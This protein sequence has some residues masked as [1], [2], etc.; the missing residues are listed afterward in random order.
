MSGFADCVL[1]GN[2]VPDVEATKLVSSNLSHLLSKYPLDGHIGRACLAPI[3]YL[4]HSKRLSDSP[5]DGRHL[6]EVLDTLLGCSRSDDQLILPPESLDSKNHRLVF[7]YP[8]IGIQSPWSS[9]VMDILLASKV[10]GIIQIERLRCYLLALKGGGI[11]DFCDLF[12]PMTEVVAFEIPAIS[13]IFTAQLASPFQDFLSTTL[14]IHEIIEK[15]DRQLGLGLGDTEKSLLEGFYGAKRTPT[16]AELMMFAQVHSEHCRHKLFKAQWCFSKRLPIQPSMF[17]HIKATYAANPDGVVLAY[18][19]NAAIIDCPP[20]TFL[21]ACT[22]TQALRLVK[23]RRSYVIKAET[24]NHP[25]AIAPYQGAATGSGGEIR[26]EVAVGRGGETLMAFAAFCVSDLHIPQYLMA[27]EEQVC[28]DCP[29]I[30]SPLAIMLEAPV[31]CANYNNEFGRP[32]LCG[33]FRTLLCPQGKSRY[34]GYHK[35]IMLVGGVG[36]VHHACTQKQTLPAGALVVQ[37]GG[38]ALRIG[39]GGGTGSSS[40]TAETSQALDFASVQ[41]E[42]AQVQRRCQGVI[43]YCAALGLDNPILSI[44][45]VGAG[46]LSNAIPELLYPGGGF[47]DLESIPTMDLGMNAMEIWCNE[48]QERYVAAVKAADLTLLRKICARETCQ[49]AVLGTAQ[50]DQVLRVFDKRCGMDVVHLPMSLLFTQDAKDIRHIDSRAL[51]APPKLGEDFSPP[52]TCETIRTA[53]ERILSLPSV[54]SKSFLITIGDRTVGGL[55]ARDQM[56]GPWQ[57]PVADAAVCAS[58]FDEYRG[59]ACALGERVTIA[60]TDAVASVRLALTEAV[61][62]LLSA[63]VRSLKHIK[64]SA[65]WMAD[66]TR[67][68]QKIALYQAVCAFSKLCQELG[69]V[70]PV[71]KDSLSMSKTWRTENDKITVASPVSLIVSTFSEV[72][73]IRKSLTPVLQIPSAGQK[74]ASLF[75]IDLG[76]R[77]GSVRFGGSAFAQVYRHWDQRPPDFTKSARLLDWHRVLTVLRDEKKILAYHDCS[78][79]GLFTCLVEMAFA[80]RCGVDCRFDSMSEKRSIAQILFEESPAVVVQL[81]QEGWNILHREIQGVSLFDRVFA[82]GR[83]V[84]TLHMSLR[85][86]G[87]KTSWPT[88]YLKRLWSE[89]SFWLQKIRGDAVSAEEELAFGCDPEDPGL[90]IKV[91]EGTFPFQPKTPPAFPTVIRR[92]KPKIAVLREQGSNGHKEMAAAFLFAG[93]EVYDVHMNDL[94]MGRFNLGRMLGMAICGGFSYGDACGAGKGWAS[95]ILHNPSLKQSFREFF[96]RDN[97]F[98]LGVCNG[99]Q[100][101]SQIAKLIPGASDWPRLER[102]ASQQFEARLVMVKITKT[103]SVFLSSMQGWHLPVAVAHSEGR[104]RFSTEVRRDD[105]KICMQYVD[106]HGRPTQHYPQ[107]PNAS[108]QAV[109]GVCSQ[110]GRVTIMMPHPERLFRNCQFSY[111]PRGWRSEESP[112]SESF[113]SAYRFATS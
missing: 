69:I 91:P 35:P 68:S 54:A 43:E 5:K 19:D 112:W 96:E 36:W 31:G 51:P 110:G 61:L 76:D 45:D 14:P 52:D 100:M 40:G 108:D 8:R 83:V 81:T 37:L 56:V 47:I 92:G 89:N 27:W 101:L 107:N 42:N 2:F 21:H 23:D 55:S 48:S 87:W 34:W 64:V 97:T 1:Y 82:I 105:T 113:R 44:H 67:D 28:M 17:S 80:G 3:Y 77:D 25:T 9:K 32:V 111:L 39:L 38:G 72:G 70:A 90:Y 30:A 99:C 7:V 13:R 24:H 88:M 79:G 78:D 93:F 4:R 26:D 103:P 109:A 106:N 12:D 84:G 71:G 102:N 41:R 59:V 6:D 33:A 11:D 85:C 10:Y 65:N 63:D 94:L 53:A 62:N 58:G 50:K 75:Y 49:L 16:L 46:G 18:T 74:D 29:H 57:I 98:T 22:K 95:S 15:Y 86:K 66:K 73:D 60:I 104:C 20:S